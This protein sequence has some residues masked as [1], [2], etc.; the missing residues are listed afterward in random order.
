VP[1]III[2]SRQSDLA[3][4]QALTVAQFLKQKKPNLEI[5]FFNRPSFGDLNLDMNL[6]ETNSKGVFTQEFKTLLQDKVCDVVVHSWKDLPIEDDPNTEILTLTGREDQRD[7][8]FLKKSSYGL[9]TLKILTSSPRREYSLQNSLSELL[10]FETMHLQIEPIRGNIPT[11]FA[12]FLDSEADGFVVAKAAVDRLMATHSGELATEFQDIRNQILQVFEQCHYMVLP[13]SEFPTAAAQG[14]LALEVLK[15]NPI[16]KDL[17]KWASKEDFELV[18]LERSTHKKYGGGCHQ[19]MGFSAL[20]NEF[21]TVFFTRGTFEDSVVQTQSF[22]PDNTLKTKFQPEDLFSQVQ[23][24]SE[25]SK[26]IYDFEDLNSSLKKRLQFY[27]GDEFVITRYE[28]KL[29]DLKSKDYTVWV[30]GTKTWAKLAQEGYWINGSLDGL[31][32]EHKPEMSYLKPKGKYWL[33]NSSSP[34]EGTQE[35]KT[36]ATYDLTYVLD[37]DLAQDLQDKKC[38]LWMSG[39]GF[40]TALKSNPELK[41]KIHFCGLGR[42]SETLKKH[43]KPSQIYY[44]MNE[45]DFIQ[46]VLK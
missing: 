43:L 40:E 20:K 31:G 22:K 17:K 25:R 30:S 44:C 33:T 29:E 1:K 3:R 32:L 12:K 16:L 10:P 27:K 36:I 2:G 41:N 39:H 26:T 21:G 4:I 15:T 6:K 38:F 37:D 46:Q 23:L 19:A 35:F 11:R 45:D 34:K 28:A 7:I 18:S 13:L 24:K 9:G 8:F 5:S 14:A 42:T